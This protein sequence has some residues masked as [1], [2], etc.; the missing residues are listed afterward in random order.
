MKSAKLNTCKTKYLSKLQN[1]RKIIPL[2]D[3]ENDLHFF[4]T[5]VAI[6]IDI[7]R[8]HPISMKRQGRKISMGSKVILPVAG[9]EVTA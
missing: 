5:I 8:E 3:A 4:Q 7:L 2:K 1:L 6:I 9:D